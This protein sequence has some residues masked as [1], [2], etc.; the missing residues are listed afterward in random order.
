MHGR[1]RGT[2]RHVPKGAEPDHD[3]CTSGLPAW[4]ACSYAGPESTHPE[5]DDGDPY[6]GQRLCL[7]VSDSVCSQRLCFRRTATWRGP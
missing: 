5:T 7:L 4:T 1:A 2:S 6:R 3:A